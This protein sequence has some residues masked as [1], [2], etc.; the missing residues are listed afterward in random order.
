M[1]VQQKDITIIPPDPKYD[2][3]I[4]YNGNIKEKFDEIV[5]EFNETVG[6]EKGIVVD[7]QSQGDVDQLAT[8]V[9]NSVNQAIGSSPMPDLFAAYPDTALSVHKIK[10]LVNLEKYFTQDELNEYRKEFLEEGEAS[11]N[12]G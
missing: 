2:S 8:S 4:R 12:K 6:M 3:H 10:G 11:N 1:K 9:Q 7:A 5:S